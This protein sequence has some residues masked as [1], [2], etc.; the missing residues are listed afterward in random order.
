MQVSLSV[1]G[2]PAPAFFWYYLGDDDKEFRHLPALDG[3]DNLKIEDFSLEDCG[4]YRCQV[5]GEWDD[6]IKTF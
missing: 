3:S 2:N 4:R 6:A 1:E 5:R